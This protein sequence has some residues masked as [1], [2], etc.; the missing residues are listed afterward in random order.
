MEIIL[1]GQEVYHKEIYDGNEKMKIVGIR[2][3]EVELEGDYSG[4]THEVKQKGWFPITGLVIN[5][6]AMYRVLIVN[7]LMKSIASLGRKFFC[8]K[9]KIAYLSLDQFDQVW[10]H[11][12]WVSTIHPN[13]T[14]L[15]ISEDGKLSDFHHGGN[16]LHLIREFR[17]YILTGEQPEYSGLI[18][19]DHWGYSKEEINKIILKAKSLGYLTE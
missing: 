14:K 12:E 19:S 15:V 16:L 4:G 11:K 6:D 17:E 8:N 18:Y 9:N 10:Y 5:H 1:L 13:R 7:E 3:N 2:E